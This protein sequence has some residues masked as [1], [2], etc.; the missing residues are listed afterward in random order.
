MK[1]FFF[2]PSLILASGHALDMWH[3]FHPGAQLELLWLA[4]NMDIDLFHKSGVN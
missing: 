4:A 1:G 2:I 3:Q